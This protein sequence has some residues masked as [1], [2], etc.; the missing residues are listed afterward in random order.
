MAARRPR[1]RPYNAT[2]IDGFNLNLK[3][4]QRLIDIHQEITG[5]SAGRKHKVEVLNSSAVVLLVACWEAFVE[6]LADAS[7]D[8]LLKKARDHSIVPNSV[9]TR[10]SKPLVEDL[11]KRRVWELAG[12]GWKKVLESHR[13]AIKSEYSGKLNTPK[14]RQVNDLFEKMIG[15]KRVSRSWTWSRATVDQTERKLER[16]VVLRGEI[17]HRV[18]SAAG[19]RKSHVLAHMDFVTGLVVRTHNRANEHLGKL[20]GYPPWHEYTW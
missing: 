10:A 20:T 2:H 11:D 16:L 9:L 5:D 12:A 3:E 4:V 19:V 1:G 14:P 15:L 6:D 18:T 7:F 8:I 13:K 17:A